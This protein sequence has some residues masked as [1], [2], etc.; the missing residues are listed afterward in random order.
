MP[1]DPNNPEFHPEHKATPPLTDLN[2]DFLMACY[3]GDLTRAE[4]TLGLGANIDTADPRNGMTALHLATGN[5]DSIIVRFLIDK[6][7]AFI[8]DGF[9]RLPSTVAIEC[10][11]DDTLYLL[12]SEKEDQALDAL[13]R[14]TATN[15]DRGT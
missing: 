12:I 10:D 6:G 3:N 5:N 7:A 14:K 1:S 4:T 13:A 8:H 15:K 2:A 11:I 9:N